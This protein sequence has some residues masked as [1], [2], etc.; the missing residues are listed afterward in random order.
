MPNN[1][2]SE[3]AAPACDEESP[4]VSTE[5]VLLP[6]MAFAMPFSLQPDGKQV[7]ITSGGKLVCHHG[8]LSSTISYWMAVEKNARLDGN[9]VPV[10]GGSRG[11]PTTCDCQS[12]EGLNA[13][14]DADI[15][16]PLPPN[17]LYDFLEAKNTE[18]IRVKGRDARRV[19][20]VHGPTFLTPTGKLV[21]RHGV[22]TTVLS[23]RQKEPPIR[24]ALS[25]CSC[26][27]KGL[28]TR[29]GL[30]GLQLGRCTGK[31]VMIAR[32]QAQE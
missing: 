18:V 15:I 19:P 7:Y 27:L 12:T 17:S 16:L 5:M 29:P 3:A 2:G 6:S 21:C 30:K 14:P 11:A 28:P 10:R 1:R 8:E 13:K 20:H 22:T 23:R 24:K 9:P 4:P 31:A 26:I 32:K 25:L